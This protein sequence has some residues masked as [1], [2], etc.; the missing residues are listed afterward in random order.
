MCLLFVVVVAHT[1]LTICTS[2]NKQLLHRFYP[3][4]IN[5]SSTYEGSKLTFAFD[6]DITTKSHTKRS[7]SGEWIYGRFSQLICPYNI[8]VI[9]GKRGMY[10][11]WLNGAQL[12]LDGKGNVNLFKILLGK[13]PPGHKTQK[14]N[15]IFHCHGTHTDEISLPNDNFTKVALVPLFT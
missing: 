14:N 3:V 8:T 5:Q 15:T 7:K 1:L 4:Q 9:N 11:S 12:T 13:S 2:S 10:L 6:D